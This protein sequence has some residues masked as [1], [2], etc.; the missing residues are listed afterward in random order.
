VTTLTLRLS[1]LR[2]LILDLIEA[3]QRPVAVL[4][5]EYE[6]RDLKQEMLELAPLVRNGEH[7]PEEVP[8]NEAICL[9]EG[10]PVM[11]SP[12]VPRGKAW[13]I[14]ESGRPTVH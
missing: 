8:D 10:V 7:G 11:S 14:P 5:S 6:K 13:I 12:D 3:G 9:I 1:G 4:L 2:A